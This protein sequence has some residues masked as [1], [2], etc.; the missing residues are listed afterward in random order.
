MILS[1]LETNNEPMTNHKIKSIDHFKHKVPLF[2][3][4]CRSGMSTTPLQ[5]TS[6][7]LVASE[8]FP[9]LVVLYPGA[10]VNGL[11]NNMSFPSWDNLLSIYNLTDI[12]QGSALTDLQRLEVLAGSYFC[13]AG[14]LVGILKPGR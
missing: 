5:V 8:I 10:I 3:I 14:A 2:R 4:P 7:Q 11:I 1:Q 9:L 6:S 12:K 13:V